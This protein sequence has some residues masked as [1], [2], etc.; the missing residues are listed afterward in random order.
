MATIKTDYL[1]EILA[2]FVEDET[3]FL[4][5]QVFNP[6]IE[7]IFDE[8]LFHWNLLLEQNLIQRSDDSIHRNIRKDFV[9]H[10]NDLMLTNSG[11]N[12]YNIK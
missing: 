5:T 3:Y 4:N 8:F 7:K 2:K 11:Y 12:F 10:N 1:K 9:Q 6:L